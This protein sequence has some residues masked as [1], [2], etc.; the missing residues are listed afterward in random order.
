M[1]FLFFLLIPTGNA[2]V[3]NHP[4]KYTIIHGE[5]YVNYYTISGYTG[6]EKLD[7]DT[8][9]DYNYNFSN[10]FI[11]CDYINIKTVSITLNFNKNISINNNKRHLTNS[12]RNTPDNW[13]QFH[14]IIN[15]TYEFI[16]ITTNMFKADEDNLIEETL[17]LD[18]F[19]S[20]SKKSQVFICEKSDFK[21]IQE[22]NDADFVNVLVIIAALIILCNSL[23]YCS[24]NNYHSSQ[25]KSVH[26]KN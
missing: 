18:N 7:P 1:N 15:Y 25:Y 6:F 9:C 12:L 20:Y 10:N 19:K 14:K 8:Y 13:V 22:A 16:F 21:L 3:H 26:T 24:C 5:P 4:P 23:K 17:Y 2:M 11:C